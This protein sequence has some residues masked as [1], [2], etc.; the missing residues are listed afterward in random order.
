MPWLEASFDSFRKLR[1]ADINLGPMR[2]QTVRAKADPNVFGWSSDAA[3]A[4][5]S[6]M[7]SIFSETQAGHETARS[8]VNGA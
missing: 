7:L 1:V 6:A 8:F 4:L 2:A 5:P 3:A